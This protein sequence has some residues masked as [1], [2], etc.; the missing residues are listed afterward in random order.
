APLRFGGLERIPDLLE[1]ASFAR[2]GPAS[3]VRQRGRP[4][5]LGLGMEEL[6]LTLLVTSLDGR[7]GLEND[8]DAL[9]TIHPHLGEIV[10]QI[11]ILRAHIGIRFGIIARWPISI[12]SIA[13]SWTLCRRM[14]GSPT[15]ICRRRSSP[16]VRP[17]PAG[18]STR[19]RSLADLARLS[20]HA[21]G[22][23]RADRRRRLA[24]AQQ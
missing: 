10:E 18:R 13:S 5:K 3:T 11:S 22:P 23:D 16:C 15:R 14:L 17:R 8:L 2:A 20:T 19:G 1:A 12:E 21:Q 7:E 24:G 9:C 6:A 4:V